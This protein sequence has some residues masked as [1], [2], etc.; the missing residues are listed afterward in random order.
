MILNTPYSQ[1][2]YEKLCG[3]II[4]HMKTT[5]EWGEFFPTELATFGYNETVAHEYFPMTETA[6]KEK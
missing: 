6:V 3:K 2:E 1:E 4:D 5:L